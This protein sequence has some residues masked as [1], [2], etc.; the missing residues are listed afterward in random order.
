MVSAVEINLS[1]ARYRRP[2]V[3]GKSLRLRCS[4]SQV[5]RYSVGGTDPLTAN[6]RDC[7]S[8]CRHDGRPRTSRPNQPGG[9]V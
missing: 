3:R 6:R 1:S 5:A 4:L 9:T 2:T 7:S 8:L